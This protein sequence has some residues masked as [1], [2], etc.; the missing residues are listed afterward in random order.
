LNQLETLL[1]IYCPEQ[2]SPTIA[3]KPAPCFRKRK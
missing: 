1:S 3:D 2:Q